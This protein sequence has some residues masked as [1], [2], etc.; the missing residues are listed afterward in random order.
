MIYRYRS[1]CPKTIVT[2]LSGRHDRPV[3]DSH[4]HAQGRGKRKSLAAIDL[5]SRDREQVISST[6]GI[7][8]GFI[9][10]EISQYGN[11]L[12]H[13]LARECRHFKTATIAYLERDGFT[14]ESVEHS[15]A[16]ESSI[17]SDAVRRIKAAPIVSARAIAEQEY[18]GLVNQPELSKLALDQIEA[19]E[20]RQFLGLPWDAE[21]TPEQVISEGFGKGRKQLKNLLRITIA[22]QALA[23][24][25]AVAD[26]LGT[27]IYSRDM[28]NHAA[29]LHSHTALAFDEI[30][31]YALSK[32][33]GYHNGDPVIREWWNKLLQY[34][35]ALSA[36]PRLLG[37]TLPWTAPGDY[38]QM[39]SVLGM[40]LNSKGFRTANTKRSVDGKQVRV[41]H[42]TQESIAKVTGQILESIAEDGVELLGTPLTKVLMGGVA[43]SLDSSLKEAIESEDIPKIEYFSRLTDTVT[44]LF[45]PIR[46]TIAA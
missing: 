25:R 10:D 18:L 24:D 11:E 15:T 46:E 6:T 1:D 41:Y 13:R 16:G 12:D 3:G 32:S 8:F 17:D 27:E 40:I 34:Q 22:G 26:R 35:N 4:R 45:D 29:S 38:S 9:H 44:P 21:L 43:Y 30:L 28:S 19:Y 42:V 36:Q 20:I 14:V 7:G 5:N 31:A 2:A 37:F 33:E 39:L 23:D